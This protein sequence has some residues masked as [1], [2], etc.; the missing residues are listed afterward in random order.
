MAEP[1]PL[2]P[3]PTVSAPPLGQRRARF[4]RVR[5]LPQAQGTARAFVAGGKARIATD[6]NRTNSPLGAWRAAVATEARREYG[7]EPASRA[8]IKLTIVWVWPRPKAH[9]RGGDPAKGLRADAPAWK[10][11]KPDI[12]KTERAVLDALTGIAYVDDAQVVEV[13]KRKLWGSVAGA[14]IAITEL[15]PKVVD[16]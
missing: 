3:T 15:D 5:G 14:D 1:R 11:S 7:D 4:L 13:R 2:F 9:Y 16:R 12:D 6:A 10:S 8:P